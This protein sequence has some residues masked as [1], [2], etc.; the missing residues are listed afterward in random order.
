MKNLL[1]DLEIKNL[2]LLINIHYSSLLINHFSYKWKL[3]CKTI[4]KLLWK[5]DNL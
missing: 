1:M 5:W 2:A 3:S 4:N